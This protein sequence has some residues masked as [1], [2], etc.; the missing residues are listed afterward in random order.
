MKNVLLIIDSYPPEIR[1]ASHLMEEL[2]WEFRDKGYNVYVATSYPK[3]NLSEQY[4]GKEYP[5]YNEEN[6]I[7]VIRIKTL[8][9]HKVNFIVRGI[10][11]LTMPNIFYKKIRKYI[12]NLDFVMIYSPPL[13]LATLGKNIK[14]DYGA[15]FILNVQDIFPQNAIDL[16][17][18]KNKILIR[19]FKKMEYKVYKSADIIT[20]HSNGNLEFI[21]SNYPEFTNKL[22]ILHNWIDVNEFENIKPDGKFR[23]LFNLKDKF[24]ILFAGVIGP[25]Q[26]LDFVIN[27]AERLKDIKELVFLMVGDGMERSNLENLVKLKNLRNVIFKDFVSKKEYPELVKDCNIGLVSLTNKNRTPVVPGKIL[28]YMAAGMP[29]LAFLNKES[30]GHHI[31]K[32]ANCGY[33]C[34]WGDIETAEKLIRQMYT[35]R[36]TIRNLGKNG[37]LYVRTNFEKKHIIDKLE[38]LIEIRK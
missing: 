13:P 8:P 18:L 37:Y 26:G 20:V 29:V 4:K 16:G 17:I 7:K 25:S 5:E 34:E 19:Y 6:S 32:E 30:D 15:L 27:V 38:K 11:Q 23:E 12:K 14:K 22:H 2:A 24:I 1:S 36:D 28:G 10:A 21:K 31:I 3:Y 33:S 9:H 35:N